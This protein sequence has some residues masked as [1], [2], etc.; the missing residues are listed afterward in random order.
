MSIQQQAKPK[1]VIFDMD[2][3]LVDVS[4]VRH[5]VAKPR[6]EKDFDAFHAA[7]ID[8]PPVKRAMELAHD[9]HGQGYTIVVVTAR[10]QKWFYTSF[11]WLQENMEVPFD[12]PFMRPDN[13]FRPDVQIKR[14]IFADVSR[15]YDIHAAVDDNPAVITL[16][17]ELGLDVTIIP[18]WDDSMTVGDKDGGLVK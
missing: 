9:Y 3:T 12:G 11:Y 13:D 6:G 7:S 10:V 5:H 16:W 1:A 2:G 8:C 18:G 17:Q 4:S 15:H 14:E